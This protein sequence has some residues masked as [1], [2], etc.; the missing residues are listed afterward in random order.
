MWG[1]VVLVLSLST[2]EKHG[3]RQ[4]NRG[5]GVTE[6]LALTGNRNWYLTVVFQGNR[7]CVLTEM[8]SV[9]VTDTGA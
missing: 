6:T 3:L 2:A 7:D 5:R 1:V 8:F 4:A 9:L